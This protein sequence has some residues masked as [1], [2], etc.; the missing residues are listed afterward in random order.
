[1]GMP[2]CPTSSS[3]TPTS[4]A[5]WTSA[6]WASAVGRSISPRRYGS[7]DYNLGPGFGGEFLRAYGWPQDDEA[8]VEQLRLSYEAGD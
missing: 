6:T 1:M 5:T 3:T 2:A 4:R 7:L 8:T